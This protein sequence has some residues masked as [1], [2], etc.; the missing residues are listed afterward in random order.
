MRVK[1]M[2]P[3]GRLQQFDGVGT[4]VIENDDGQPVCVAGV[5]AAGAVYVA[6]GRDPEFEDVKRMLGLDRTSI[7][8]PIDAE[9]KKP[10]DL[11]VI[12]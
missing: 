12:F 9:L 6:H 7:V 1:I 8:I 5:I 3:F 10:Q 4:V 2:G 11:S